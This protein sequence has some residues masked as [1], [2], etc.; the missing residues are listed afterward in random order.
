MFD[1]GVAE[2]TTCTVV[3]LQVIVP[4][5]AIVTVKPTAGLTVATCAGDIHPLAPIAKTLYV[6]APW[7]DAVEAPE[8]RDLRPGRGPAG[9]GSQDARGKKP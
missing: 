2:A 5:F 6:P 7:I 1:P 3:V 8:F 4:V 9:P